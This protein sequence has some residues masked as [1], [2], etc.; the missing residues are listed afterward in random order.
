MLMGV[1]DSLALSSR[2]EEQQTARLSELVGGYQLSQIVACMAR[3]D[4]AT[5]IADGERSTD[6]LC[7]LTGARPE[8][9][10]RFLRAAAGLGLLEEVGPDRFGLSSLGSWLRSNT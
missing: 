3:L 10:R 5:H 8:S 4:I 1:T 7:Q 6:D 2:A 9:L